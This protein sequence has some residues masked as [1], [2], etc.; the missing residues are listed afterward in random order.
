MLVLDEADRVLDMGFTT[1]SGTSQDTRG[2]GR[3]CCSAPPCP[4]IPL[5]PGSARIR[6]SRC[7]VRSPRQRHRR[8]CARWCRDSG[9]A[10]GAPA[11]A[12]SVTQPLVC[13]RTNT[14]QPPRRIS[15]GEEERHLA[16]QFT[17]TGRSPSTPLRSPGFRG[18]FRCWSPP[19]SRLGIGANALGSHVIASTCRSCGR[20]HA[21]RPHRG[22]RSHGEAHAGITGRKD[23]CATSGAR[24]AP[25]AARHG[26]LRLHRAEKTKSKSIAC[27]SRGFIA[28]RDRAGGRSAP[29][30]RRQLTAVSQ[31]RRGR[32]TARRQAR[33]S[34][35]AGDGPSAIARRTSAPSPSGR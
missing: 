14:R 15:G 34:R 31:R 22:R 23:R 33:R 12:A 16:E 5:S 11:H 4:P 32:R 9:L 29:R 28:Q 2:G 10:R 17:T 8:R 30:A 35:P 13:A 21:R 7:S 6:P 27:A 19:T 24:S 18:T 3:R 26:A 25:A 1:G 20:L